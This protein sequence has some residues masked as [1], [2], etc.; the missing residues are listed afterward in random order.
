M[1]FKIL[2]LNFILKLLLK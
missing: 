2:N 1:S